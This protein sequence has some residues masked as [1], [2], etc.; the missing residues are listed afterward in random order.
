MRFYAG[1]EK[2]GK[3]GVHRLQPGISVELCVIIYSYFSGS[4]S[5]SHWSN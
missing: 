5:S 1:E 4:R 2:I 3:Q